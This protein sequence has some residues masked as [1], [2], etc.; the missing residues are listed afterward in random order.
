MT[1]KSDI[2]TSTI[3][4]VL[5]IIIGGLCGYWYIESYHGE[6]LDL[7]SSVFRFYLYLNI[8]FFGCTLLIGTLHIA[9]L[10]KWKQ[11]LS[12]VL[13]SLGLGVLF[14]LIYSNLSQTLNPDLR[15]MSLFSSQVGFVIG[16]NI[17]LFWKR[18]KINNKQVEEK[19]PL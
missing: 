16:F 10:A 14:L 15:M 5:E 9:L 8:I 11:W 12:A 1:I 2:K 3:F 7:S 6:T 4:I 13:I 17:G 18:M 19:K